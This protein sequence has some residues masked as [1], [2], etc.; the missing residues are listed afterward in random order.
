ML[1]GIPK[2]QVMI[3]HIEGVARFPLWLD[4]GVDIKQI[5]GIELFVQYTHQRVHRKHNSNKVDGHL[6]EG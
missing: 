3:T 4:Y 2:A 6:H 1:I 5:L